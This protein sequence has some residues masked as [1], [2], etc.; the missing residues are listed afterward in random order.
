MYYTA[1]VCNYLLLN[2]NTKGVLSNP[3]LLPP[4]PTTINHWYNGLTPTPTTFTSISTTSF[5]AFYP[6][7]PI[8][9]SQNIILPFPR[10]LTNFPLPKSTISWIRFRR[11]RQIEKNDLFGEKSWKEKLTHIWSNSMKNLLMLLKRNP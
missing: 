11:P 3:N 7:F 8:P 4:L 6:T 10:N 5:K 2:L 1:I 9:L